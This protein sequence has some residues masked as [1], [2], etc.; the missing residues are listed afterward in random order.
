MAKRSS[1][2]KHL[3]LDWDGAA[4]PAE[5]TKARVLL[6][7]INV[8]GYY[9]LPVRI[10]SLVANQSRALIERFETRY[11]E[12]KNNDDYERFIEI[13]ANWLPEIVGFSVNIWNREAC[14]HVSKKIKE[15][16]PEVRV[17]AGG[18][19][20]TN[21]VI[22]YLA[23]VPEFDYIIDGEGEIP[24]RQFLE[25][26][27]L[28]S[29]SLRDPLLVSGLRYREN[30]ET[31]FSG[32]GQVVASLDEVPSS[33][34]AGLVPAHQKNLLG[35][36]LE[37]SRGCPFRCSFCF[38]GGRKS[39]VRIASIERLRQEAEGMVSLGATYF[40]VMDPILCNSDL[41]RLRGLTAVFERLRAANPNTVISVEV[42]ANRIT[43]QI[44]ECLKPCTIID[45]GLQTTNPDTAKAIHRPFLPEKFRQG[46]EQLRRTKSSFNLYLICGLPY[47]TLTSY[48]RGVRFVLDERPTRVFFNELC[49][50]NGTELRRRAEDLGYEF[51]PR[52]P[53]LVTSTAWM[54][55]RVLKIAQVLSKEV[56]KRYNLSARAVHVTAPWLSK[57]T[58]GKGGRLPVR[59]NSGCSLKCPGCAAAESTCPAKW[60]NAEAV[61][62]RAADMDIELTGGDGLVKGPL[63]RLI[64]QLQLAGAARIKVIAPPSTFR[65]FDLVEK[66]VH[67]GVWHFKTFLLASE[68]ES[69]VKGDKVAGMMNDLESL[70]RPFPLRGY[71]VIR[72]HLEIV[73]VADGTVPRQYRTA[74]ESAA[75]PHVTVITVPESVRK[76]GD[77]WVEVLAEAFDEGIASNH[78]IKVPRAIALRAFESM[79]GCDEILGHLE[80]LDLISRVANRPPCFQPADGD[81]LVKSNYNFL[82][83]TSQ[84]QKSNKSITKARK[85]EDTKEPYFSISCFP[86]FVYCGFTP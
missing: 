71:A 61:L 49:L 45:V 53:Y 32:Q 29:S 43:E 80:E 42:Y 41:E 15:I 10:L 36:M 16:L 54:S 70:N 4:W 66:L 9:S 37:G 64:G 48:L 72:P 46:V 28:S 20:V 76:M 25:N 62:N 31:R 75:G 68:G 34:L 40:H 13:M 55:E 38:E 18:Q 65:D 35:V 27:D 51:D 2:W 69:A 3:E 24:F 33:I 44:A 21:S 14:V 73:L 74:I 39:K 8:P 17:L 63:L 30:G 19:E 50:L 57:E 77:E 12:L 85:Y 67:R 59:L 7:A 23:E 60:D 58:I 84:N 78:W 11:V 86:S 79:G 5:G 82:T 22:D 52:P 81:S 47:E 26:W 56:E 6:V 83:R 1:N